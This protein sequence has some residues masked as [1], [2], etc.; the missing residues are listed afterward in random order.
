MDWKLYSFII[1][2]KQRKGILLSLEIP[3]TPTQIGNEVDS[4][5]SHVSRNLKQFTEKGIAV[6]VT[7]K[8]RIGRVYKLTDKGKQ[9]LDQLK[10]ET[11]NR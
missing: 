5:V 4:S 7:P 8:E 6:C 10:K 9:I 11:K 2:S 1:R 3:K